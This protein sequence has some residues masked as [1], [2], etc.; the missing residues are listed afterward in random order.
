LFHTFCTAGCGRALFE[1]QRHHRQAP[2]V[3]LVHQV[4]RHLELP[5]VDAFFGRAVEVELLQAR[6]ACRPSSMALPGARLA[7]TVWPLSMTRSGWLV[8]EAHRL[9]VDRQAAADV[10]RALALAGAAQ[11]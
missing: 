9:Q 2:L 11:R 8:V 7:C 4:H 5:A 6:S 10:D 3:V 1:Q